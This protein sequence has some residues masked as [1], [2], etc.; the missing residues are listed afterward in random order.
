MDIRHGLVHSDRLIASGRSLS[1][2]EQRQYLY[3]Q[4]GLLERS[5]RYQEWISDSL[6]SLVNFRWNQVNSIIEYQQNP[7]ADYTGVLQDISWWVDVVWKKMEYGMNVLSQWLKQINV[8]QLLGIDQAR[9]LDANIQAGFHTTL[10]SMEEHTTIFIRISSRLWEI[11]KTLQNPRKIEGLEFKRDAIGY[12]QNKWFTEALEYFRL[13]VEKLTSDQDV[14]FMM[15][16]IEFE[17]NKNYA[18]AIEH[19]EKAIKYAK[20]YND[21]NIHAQS[22]DKLASIYFIQN[23]DDPVGNTEKLKKAYTHQLEAVKISGEHPKYLFDLLKYS[24]LLWEY[25]IFEKYLYLYLRYDKYNIVD[26]FT[27]SVLIED[28]RIIKII[29]ETIENV[30]KSEDQ[31][32]K[33]NKIR[34]FISEL[35]ELNDRISEIELQELGSA[36]FDA[37]EGI[38]LDA[39]WVWFL[40]TEPQSRKRI[41]DYELIVEDGLQKIAKEYLRCWIEEQWKAVDAD[42]EL[43]KYTVEIT[44]ITTETKWPR[45]YKLNFLW[46]D[47]QYLFKWDHHTQLRIY[48]SLR[49]WLIK[50]YLIWEFDEEGY[51][52]L[53][54]FGEYFKV[55][56]GNINRFG[57][58]MYH[59]N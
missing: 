52:K 36:G 32:R 6:N 9:N 19:F 45:R 3:E 28:P 49:D 56:K 12:L 46:R 31:L 35:Y 55:N 21:A 51:G 38:A 44:D 17:E 1:N 33:Q 5:V 7:Q 22:A 50:K 8:T 10:R 43:R 37:D 30:Q 53:N 16:L 25:E 27:H 40:K 42:M 47:W 54:L 20:G 59:I 39:R 24:G 14:Y 26:L 41:R 2:A 29:N 57:W 23:W 48:Y 18:Q 15:W 4:Q 58:F 11:L 13:S 34:G